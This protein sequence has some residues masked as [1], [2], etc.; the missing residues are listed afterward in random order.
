MRAYLLATTRKRAD[1]LQ[2]R[3]G[4]ILVPT[5]LANLSAGRGGKRCLKFGTVSFFLLIINVK[6]LT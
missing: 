2:C 1:S 3:K 5:L 4:K 6:R